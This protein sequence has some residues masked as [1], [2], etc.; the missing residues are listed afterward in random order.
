MVHRLLQNSESLLNRNVDQYMNVLHSIADRCNT[1]KQASKKAQERSDIVFL[2]A[3]L[4]KQPV[5]TDGVVIGIGDKSFTVLI[6][7]K[8]GGNQVRVFVD[9]MKGI[10]SSFDKSSKTITLTNPT[11]NSFYEFNN[12]EVK[13][14]TKVKLYL[15]AKEK[16]PIDVHVDVV[17]IIT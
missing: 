11:A 7:S 17:G 1:M 2:S 12:M 6:N 10:E 15:T 9:E 3:Y 8:Y 13:L 16:V 5:Y 4:S 14:M